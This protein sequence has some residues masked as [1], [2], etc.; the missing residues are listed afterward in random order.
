[1]T[2]VNSSGL[3]FPKYLFDQKL[4]VDTGDITELYTKSQAI[5]RVWAHLPYPTLDVAELCPEF[6]GQVT[7][8][9][10]PNLIYLQ[11]LRIPE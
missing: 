8:V 5:G 4:A 7:N 9:E 11:R 1:M 10:L 3:Q 2:L 6:L